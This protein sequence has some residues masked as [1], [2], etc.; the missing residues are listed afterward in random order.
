MLEYDVIEMYYKLKSVKGVAKILN[1]GEKVVRRILINN[2][3]FDFIKDIPDK[4]EQ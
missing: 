3:I 1:L 4:E 2:H